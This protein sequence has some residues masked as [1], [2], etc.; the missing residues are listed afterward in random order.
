MDIPD[1]FGAHLKLLGTAFDRP[2]VQ[3]GPFEAA[4]GELGGVAEDDGLLRVEV[5]G[6]VFGL[7]EDDFDVDPWASE[8]LVF[9]MSEDAGHGSKPVPGVAAVTGRM[10]AAVLPGPVSDDGAFRASRHLE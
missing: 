7:G 5:L 3:M 10:P 2:M 4:S 8:R 9:N 1:G 6:V